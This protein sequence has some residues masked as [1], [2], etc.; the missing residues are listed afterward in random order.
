MP[1]TSRVFSLALLIP[2]S[3]LFLLP[4]LFSESASS[5]AV[6]AMGI[7]PT[8]T[9]T[10]T[11]T[12]PA[13]RQPTP[14]P[15][16]AVADP[17]V[18][19]RGE[20]PEALPGQEVT[21]TLEVTNQGQEAAVD[22]VVTDQ[23]PEYLEMLEVTTTQGAVTVEGQTVTVQVGV[24]GPGFVVKIVIRTRVREDTP[25]PLELEN[26]AVLTAANANDRITPPVVIRAPALLPVTGRLLP[27][28]LVYALLGSGLVALGTRLGKRILSGIP[29][30]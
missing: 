28:W 16:P 6:L 26:V 19:K 11:P 22:V 4:I 27:S 15:R 13:P 30:A 29:D 2:L 21:F 9:S 1:R 14:P 12:P 5:E 25:T 8:P 10:V 20:P 23:V 18:V 3:I 7:T 17:V 24:V